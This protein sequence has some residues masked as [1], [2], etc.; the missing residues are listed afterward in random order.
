VNRTPSRA[1][2]VQ[3]GRLDFAAEHAHVGKSQVVAQDDD[4][5]RSAGRVLGKG[6]GWRDERR[7]KHVNDG[8]HFTSMVTWGM[9]PVNRDFASAPMD[10]T[11]GVPRSIP[12]SAPARR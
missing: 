3:V 1:S 6:D 12:R 11:A 9:H 4:D 8:P 7:R 2:P 10:S 5:V